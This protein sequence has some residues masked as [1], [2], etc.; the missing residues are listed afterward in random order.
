M[1]KW[2]P[3]STAPNGTVLLFCSMVATELRD[4]FYVDWLSD[5]H[6]V[7]Q[8]RLPKPTHWMYIPQLPKDAA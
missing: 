4:A 6:L 5:G 7:K 8:P 1:A 3:I 2:Q